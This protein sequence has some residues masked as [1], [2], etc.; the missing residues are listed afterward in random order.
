[1]DR[2]EGKKKGHVSYHGGRMGTGST[3]VTNHKVQGGGDHREPGEAGK[4]RGK[5]RAGLCE[6]CAPRTSD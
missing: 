2:W 5:E 3:R 4:E 6:L 1:M